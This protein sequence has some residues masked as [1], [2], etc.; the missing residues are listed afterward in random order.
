MPA[1]PAGS[2]DAKMAVVDRGTMGYGENKKDPPYLE[3]K[4]QGRLPETW[5]RKLH[6]EREVR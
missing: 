6:G 2:P 1:L 4:K 3:A 5:I